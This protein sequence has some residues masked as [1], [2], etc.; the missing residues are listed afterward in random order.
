MS[1]EIIAKFGA[2]VILVTSGALLHS[3]CAN[4]SSNAGER[5]T[6]TRYLPPKVIGTIKSKDVVESSGLAASRCQRDVFWTH[7]DSGD[8]AYIYAINGAGDNLGTWRV[9]NAAND[10]WEDIAAFKDENGK[11]FIYIGDIGDNK[12]K[13]PEHTVYRITEPLITPTDSHSSREDPL[14]SEQ[15]RSVRFRYPD[16]SEDS[17]TL[18]VHPKTGDIYV[19]TKRVSG[20]AG[21]YCLRQPVFDGSVLKLE[22]VAEI[23][24]PAIPN[25]LVTGGDISPDGRR[26]VICDYTQ[27]YEWMLPEGDQNFDDIWK[28]EPDVV[29]LGK[30]KHGESVSYGIDGTSV[31][32]TSEGKNSVVI[33]VMRR[34]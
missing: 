26:V 4:I 28:Q 3:G 29:D 7:N 20:P 22:R 16:I 8:D 24:V 30:R 34:P 25:G 27:G 32:A 11:C 15:P 1:K 18:M 2:F 9:P 21:V 33:E 17:E 12:G 10:D 19:A 5:P 31:F 23:S 6:S 14:T 13:R